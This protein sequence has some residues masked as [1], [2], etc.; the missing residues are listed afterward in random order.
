MD[1]RRRLYKYIEFL[2][3]RHWKESK[4]MMDNRYYEGYEG[5][6]EVKVWSENNGKEDGM[7]IWIGFFY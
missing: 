6:G 2:D 1:R 4:Y 7:V 5:E 3:K